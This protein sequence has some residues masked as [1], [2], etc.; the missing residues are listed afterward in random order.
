MFIQKGSPSLQCSPPLQAEP[1][2]AGQA[3]S[4]IWFIYLGIG[5]CPSFHA[6]KFYYVKI[7][8]NPLEC[9]DPNKLIK[10]PKFHCF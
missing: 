6:F 3:A 4:N 2:Y 5:L 7:Q 8:F 10:S 9:V 1:T